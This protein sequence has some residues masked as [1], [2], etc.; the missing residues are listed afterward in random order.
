MGRCLEQLEYPLLVRG[1]R[2]VAY[3]FFARLYKYTRLYKYISVQK[4]DSV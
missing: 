1:S 3:L 4:T 2:Q